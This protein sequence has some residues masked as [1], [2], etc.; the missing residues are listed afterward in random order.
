MN[1]RPPTDLL[2]RF[3]AGDPRAL[4]RL[5]TLAESGGARG[6]AAVREVRARGAR[7]PVIGLTG[8]P[9]SGKSTLADALIAAIRA[10]GQTVG[11][12]AV[13]PTSPYS[14]G[15][16]LG[17]RVRML[18]HHADAGV[19]VRS[20]ASRGALGGLSRR[21]MS[22][23]AVMEAFGFDWLFLETVGVGQSEVD[24]ASVA[25]H[26]LLV[27]TPGAGD[28]VQAF[29]AGVME[30][31]DLL[32]VNKA[33]LPGADRL[34]RELRAAQGLAPH[35][36]DSWLPPILK[37]VAAK[38]EGAA[39]LLDAIGQ[40]RAFLGEA[41]LARRRL[42]RARFEVRAEVQDRAQRLAAGAGQSLL[43]AVAAGE[44]GAGE[45]ADVLL[46]A[47]P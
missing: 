44:L 32:V 37:T 23:S 18:R 33:D 4:A 3:R 30:I 25:D 8:S 35:G 6:E 38:G 34:V 2:G 28:A 9:G 47:R 39:A 41:G 1:G 40:H 42:G 31:A 7:A 46:G 12:L 11:V 19:F 13:D 24:I 36:A 20:L 17:D 10:R 14:G 21:A 45:A 26:T 16:I 15:A 27:L 22:A 43:D 5:L 29:K